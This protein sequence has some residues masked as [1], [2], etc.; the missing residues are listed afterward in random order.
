MIKHIVMF[1]FAE[2]A[3]GKNKQENLAIALEKLS[4]FQ[5][6]I[7]TLI[8]FQAVTNYAEAPESNYEIALICDFTDMEG[9]K[10]YQEHPVHLDF[11]AFITSVRTDRA[12]IDYQY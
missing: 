11:A 12:C 4:K 3:G 2:E 5:E 9:M 10:A 8:E 6:G 1:R 7:P